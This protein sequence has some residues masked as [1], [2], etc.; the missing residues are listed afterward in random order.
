MLCLRCQSPAVRYGSRAQVG[1]PHL[2]GPV[3]VPRG[4]M[5]CILAPFQIRHDAKAVQAAMQTRRQPTP[6]RSARP[7]P[8]PPPHW[9][10]TKAATAASCTHDRLSKGYDIH[11]PPP[12]PLCFLLVT[13][14]AASAFHRAPHQPVACMHI[15]LHSAQPDTED[16][17]TRASNPRLSRINRL[18]YAE[19][20]QP[21]TTTCP[22]PP[23]QAAEPHSPPLRPYHEP[24]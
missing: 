21:L 18:G 4:L 9:Q 13:T 15:L 22:P 12:P 2:T 11:P 7:T 3:R 16:R 24:L 5:R 14:P 23:L 20:G 8:L 1:T 19:P 17:H 10:L 6:P